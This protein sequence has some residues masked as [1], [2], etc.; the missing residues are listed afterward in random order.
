[1]QRQRGEGRR[2]GQH[3]RWAAVVQVQVCFLNYSFS[4]TKP[5]WNRSAS[6]YSHGDFPHCQ[7]WIQSPL[8]NTYIIMP[9]K[10]TNLPIHPERHSYLWKT[11]CIRKPYCNI[12]CNN[13]ERPR[14]SYKEQMTHSFT[15]VKG[16]AFKASSYVTLFVITQ[17]YHSKI[18]ALLLFF[19][20]LVLSD[21]LLH[22]GV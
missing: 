12:I 5:S 16:T 19:S 13:S 8:W 3:L 21:S 2:W 7:L 15:S 20:L 18:T 6:P 17:E 4:P 22:H 10:E 14:H 9:R 11:H 1:M